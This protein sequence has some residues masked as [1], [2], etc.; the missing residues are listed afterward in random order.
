MRST[1]TRMM[2]EMKWVLLFPSTFFFNI[3]FIHLFAAITDISCIVFPENLHTNIFPC[4]LQ[5]KPKTFLWMYNLSVQSIFQLNHI[6]RM[7][8]RFGPERPILLLS[9]FLLGGEQPEILWYVKHNDMMMSLL[10]FLWFMDIFTI[11]S[12]NT[13]ETS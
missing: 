12:I 8:L 9:M 2:T 13:T 10:I 11:N 1:N 7:E 3:W 5:P 6:C 4:P